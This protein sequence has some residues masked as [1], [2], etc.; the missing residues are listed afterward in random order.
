MVTTMEPEPMLLESRQRTLE[1]RHYR[2]IW[3][4]TVMTP[5]FRQVN[6]CRKHFTHP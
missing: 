2:V 5:P 6:Q 4:P 3:H 1:L